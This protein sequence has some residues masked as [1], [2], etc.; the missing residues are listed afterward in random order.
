[1]RGIRER[2]AAVIV[3][4]GL[5][6]L[7]VGDRVP[8][9]Q[10]G[11]AFFTV[12]ALEPER[13]LVLHSSRHIMPSMRSNEFSWAF[14]LGPQAEGVTRLLVRARARVEPWYARLALALLIGPGDFVNATAMLRGIRARRAGAG[15]G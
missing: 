12:A 2:S 6:G 1:M 15:R 10:D 14:V 8:D 7:S 11:P 4:P 9:S 5:Q 13:A 3:F